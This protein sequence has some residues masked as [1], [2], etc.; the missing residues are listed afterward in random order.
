MQ[1]LLGPEYEPLNLSLNGCK[2]AGRR[3]WTQE[4][5]FYQ[6]GASWTEFHKF[7]SSDD[8]GRANN[9]I[10]KSEQAFIKI[11]RVKWDECVII[12]KVSG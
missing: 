3:D 2:M 1:D 10:C 6:Y 12:F 4:L 5:K 11:S 9:I 8:F 7:N